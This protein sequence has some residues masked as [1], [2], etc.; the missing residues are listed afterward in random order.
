M[1]KER[2]ELLQPVTSGDIPRIKQI[3][4]NTGYKF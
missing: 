1:E 3:E 2:D 4:Q